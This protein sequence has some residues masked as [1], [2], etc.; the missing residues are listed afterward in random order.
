MESK[1]RSNSSTIH[2]LFII[3]KNKLLCTFRG[4]S[5]S[6]C[7][8]ICSIANPVGVK[9]LIRFRLGFR[10]LC[11][12]NMHNFNNILNLLCFCSLESETTCHYLLGCHNFFFACST[13]M[14]VLD[15]IN[16]IISQL[17]KTSLANILLYGDSKISVWKKSQ[18]LQGTIKCIFLT[19]HFDELLF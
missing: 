10:Y 7:C 8:P 14:N 4:V 12:H 2:S 15:L 19:K 5:L 6:T 13:L 3:Q 17:S 9:L 11:R 16:S 1:E 18:I